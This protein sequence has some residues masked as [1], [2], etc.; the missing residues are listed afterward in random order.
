MDAPPFDE[1]TL[2]EAGE[3]AIVSALTGSLGGG[4]SQSVI[5]GPGD[6][7]A[8][9]AGPDIGSGEVLLLKTDC[10]VEGVH[11][12]AM[13]EPGAVGW[14]AM[15]RTLSD[16]GAMGGTPRHALVTLVMQAE[17]R[18]GEA[19][20]I[21]GGLRRCAEQYGVEIVGGETSSGP[22]MM[23]SVAAS[24]TCRQEAMVLRSGGKPGDVICV[25]GELGGSLA[26]G[27]HLD[28][29]P[30]VKEGQ[31]LAAHVRP[32]AMMD[33]SDGLAADLPRLAEASEVGFI[34]DREAIPRAPGCGVENALIDGEDY[35]L[36]LALPG[37]RLLQS[38]SDFEGAFPGLKLTAIGELTAERT[39]VDALGK[40]WEHFSDNEGR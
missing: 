38:R 18:V 40:G 14:K 22:V 39:K 19:K 9:V 29:R 7:C 4:A 10:V 32:S 24:G 11:F 34:I 33:L 15:A 13:A 21:F 36:L 26:S 28:F 8:A 17:R 1:A 23:I 37:E 35:E 5:V 3:E 27:R 16:F 30:R 12:D 25:T 20:D 6:D 31:W 2:R